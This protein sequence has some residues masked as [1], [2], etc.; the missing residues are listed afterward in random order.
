M[1]GGGIMRPTVNMVIF[2][3]TKVI[4]SSRKVQIMGFGE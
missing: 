4:E 3:V 2:T 1:I